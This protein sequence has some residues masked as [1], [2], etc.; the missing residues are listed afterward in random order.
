MNILIIDGPHKGDRVEASVMEPKSSLKLP[1][2]PEGSLVV[3]PL[4]FPLSIPDITFH[5][6]AY[7]YAGRLDGGTHA[8]SKE[9]KRVIEMT[10]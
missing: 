1:V 10:V 4:S 9:N 5:I 6:Q 2:F 3:R 7:F 8:Y